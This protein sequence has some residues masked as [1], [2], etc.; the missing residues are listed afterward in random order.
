MMTSKE[1]ERKFEGIWNADRILLN[2]LDYSNEDGFITYK[3]IK[4][5][6]AYSIR[7]Q[8][9]YAALRAYGKIKEGA[10]FK[11]WQF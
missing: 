5:E 2:V 11:K 3:D 10:H 8:R 9:F 4:E 1:K 7:L 6:S